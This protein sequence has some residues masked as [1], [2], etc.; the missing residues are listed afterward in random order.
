MVQTIG[1]F[2]VPLLRNAKALALW[3]NMTKIIKVFYLV[4]K[5]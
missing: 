1:H 5:P 3:G 4:L 2:H